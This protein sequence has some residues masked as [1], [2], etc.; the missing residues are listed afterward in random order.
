[1]AEFNESRMN[2]GAL[3]R[4][5]SSITG[6]LG[7]A[8]QVALYKYNGT[9][10]E[11]EPPQIEGTLFVFERSI[12]PS[13]GFIIMNRLS[14]INKVEPITHNLEFQ[15]QEPF[16][17]YR[18]ANSEINGIWFYDR[19]ECARIGQYM[20]SLSQY[21]SAEQ[22][23][24]KASFNQRQRRAS[25]SD[26]LHDSKASVTENGD[27]VSLL[28]KALNDYK[29]C[30]TSPSK[31]QKKPSKSVSN[32]SNDSIIKP[33]PVRA[34]L[35][36]SSS[37]EQ[38][39]TALSVEALFASAGKKEEFQSK[40]TSQNIKTNAESSS[41]LLKR[42]MSNPENTVEHIERQ[43]N[44]ESSETLRHSSISDVEKDLKER[45][46]LSPS[47]LNSVPTSIEESKT[48]LSNTQT[49]QSRVM[50][51][52]MFNQLPAQSKSNETN[53]SAPI[54]QIPANSPL[55]FIQPMDAPLMSPMAFKQS[56]APQPAVL[57]SASSSTVSNL[58]GASGDEAASTESIDSCND[59]L[60]FL[61]K[62][63]PLSK[64]FVP[65]N[66]SQLSQALIHLL[67]VGW[68]ATY[69]GQQNTPVTTVPWLPS[70]HWV[71]G[72]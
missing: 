9:T 17:L 67:Q 30:G 45:L 47:E 26:S 27:I 62:S 50:T 51:P 36:K 25:E 18:N 29:V 6:I 37:D 72:T 54:W 7:T 57:P 41:A 43:M 3:Q 10:G 68:I 58:F 55:N 42:L 31:K 39:L 28:T 5:D 34:E 44:T 13:T 61:P 4:I 69:F 22:S 8:S 14:V 2:L 19:D 63:K 11:W 12:S 23:E 66:K 40:K 46:H 32:G 52:S 60:E 53:N 33:T 38:P 56:P 21:A 35:H 16:L 64:K 15:L 65:L 1:M 49:L 24:S 48:S 70:L 20:N 71:W 59:L